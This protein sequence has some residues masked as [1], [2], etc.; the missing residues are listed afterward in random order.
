MPLAKDFPSFLISGHVDRHL[1]NYGHL[2]NHRS[3]CADALAAPPLCARSQMPRFSSLPPTAIPRVDLSV[4]QHCNSSDEL[5]LAEPA[6]SCDSGSG[7]RLLGLNGR[8]SATVR[9]SAR[10]HKCPRVNCGLRA[11]SS[12]SLFLLGIASSVARDTFSLTTRALTSSGNH[13]RPICC[14]LLM[15]PSFR[16]PTTSRL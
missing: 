4:L 13:S 2:S 15:R 8:L 11:S 1:S 7:C 6:A 14:A 12:A 9:R 16:L 3:N 5:T 10:L